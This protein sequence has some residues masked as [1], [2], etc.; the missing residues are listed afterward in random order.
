MTLQTD[1]D[2]Y[3]I[4]VNALL[5]PEYAG[6][7]SLPAETVLVHG[8]PTLTCPPFS[9]YGHAWLELG[10]AV[11]DFSNGKHVI[12]RREVYYK[13][14]SINPDDC[15]RYSQEEARKW[16]LRMKHYGPWEGPEANE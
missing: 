8:R 7:L 3:E 4:A 6:G 1:G 12:T 14:G 15:L 16:V 13:A 11:F 5:M 2:C 10:D 9:E